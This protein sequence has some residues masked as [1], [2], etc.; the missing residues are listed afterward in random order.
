MIA[1]MIIPVFK[2]RANTITQVQTKLCN[3]SWEWEITYSWG[4]L[5]AWSVTDTQLSSEG[6]S[7]SMVQTLGKMRLKEGDLSS[8]DFSAGTFR[9]H[10]IWWGRYFGQWGLWGVSNYTMWVAAYSSVYGSSPVWLGACGLQVLIG[11]SEGG[12]GAVKRRK[13]E[14]LKPSQGWLLRKRYTWKY[15]LKS[16]LNILC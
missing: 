2:H 5:K 14:R 12:G 10:D 11:R 1:D 7:A 15:V 16:P 8:S 3:F 6:N 4:N 9:H 13:G